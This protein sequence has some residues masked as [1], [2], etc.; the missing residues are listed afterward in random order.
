MGRIQKVYLTEADPSYFISIYNNCRQTQ[1][2]WVQKYSPGGNDIPPLARLVTAG[3]VFFPSLSCLL[4][5]WRLL[6]CLYSI[7][8]LQGK[9]NEQKQ[10]TF[11]D[12]NPDFLYSVV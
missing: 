12:P 10:A 6:G 7:P 5:A 8:T 3:Q 9:Q 4:A 11:H 2:V 1:K